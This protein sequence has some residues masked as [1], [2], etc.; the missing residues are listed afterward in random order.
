MYRQQRN[1]NEKRLKT[2]VKIGF[3]LLDLAHFQYNR[4]R[5]NFKYRIFEQRAQWIK[6]HGN[7]YIFSRG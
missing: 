6:I 3:D 5:L 4:L 2:Y 7:I 1:K